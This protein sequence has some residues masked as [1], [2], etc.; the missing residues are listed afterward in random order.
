[1]S[2]KLLVLVVCLLLAV[3]AIYFGF[4]QKK[5]LESVT[6]P[7]V[8]ET[9]TNTYLV[10]Y[11]GDFSNV[12]YELSYPKD[13]FSVSSKVTAPS[14]VNLI[15]LKNGDLNTI[16]FFY[17][18]A[19]GFSSASQL[20]SEQYKSKCNDCFKTVGMFNY[21][22]ND[23]AIYS[24]ATDEWVIFAQAP[25]FVVAHFK[26]PAT[27]AI[28]ILESLK[29]TSEKTSQQLEFSTINVYFANEKIKPTTD[30]K[31]V[32]AVKREILKTPKIAQATMET[33]LEG[34]SDQEKTEGYTSSIP[35]GA[36]LNSISITDG[37]AYV[38]FNKTT[39][40]GGGSC[41]MA[42]RV[43][44]IRQTLL[45]FPTIKN[46]ILSIDGQTEPIFQP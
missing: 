15:N 14:T 4:I 43:S 17:N 23:I 21:P 46:V 34:P 22:S 16:Y 44:Q 38:D 30:C 26:K 3:I 40:S 29:I 5:P 33:L 18:G 37:V 42:M 1:M 35:T 36:S 10:D 9:Y 45:Q 20:W 27:D 7:A 8:L 13:S 32:L 2:K 24:S 25:G 19:A 11:E 31:E 6:A 12:T 39:E 28:K 41:S